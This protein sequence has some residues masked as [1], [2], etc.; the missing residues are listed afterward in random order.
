MKLARKC[1]FPNG[2]LKITKVMPD[3]HTAGLVEVEALITTQMGILGKILK[4]PD[5]FAKVVSHIIHYEQSK[6]EIFRFV[7]KSR[8][9]YYQ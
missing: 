7:L 6:I 3:C 2:I 8:V 1:P 9:V 5:Y 4:A